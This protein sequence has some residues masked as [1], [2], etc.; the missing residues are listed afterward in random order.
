M[1]GSG[2][3]R[4]Y[5][6]FFTSRGH[7]AIARANL[8][9]REDATTLFTGSGMQPLVPYLLG[10]SHPA[11][12]RLVDSQPSLRAE[13]ID[14]I[15][16]TRHTTLFEMLGNW[17]LGS[18]FKQEQL[19]WIFEFLT[20]VVGL[21][22]SRIFASVF[23]G[24]PRWDIPRDTESELIWKDLFAD[25]GVDPV[26]AEP[27]TSARAALT[28]TGNAP[29]VAYDESECWWSRSGG[30]DTMPPGEPGG[31]DSEVFYFYP[32]VPHDERFGARC[33]P[34][35][36]CGR[37]VEIGN[38]VFMQYRRTEDGIE[39]LSQRNVDFGGGL[40]RLA[41][42]AI[43]TADVFGIDLLAPLVTAIESM[44]ASEHGSDVRAKRII[45]DHVRAVSFLAVD[46][47][48]PSNNTQGYV[49]RRL[50]RR[51][52]RQGL[53]LGIDAGLLPVLGDAVAAIYRDAYPE[54]GAR[55]A[56]ISSV[57]DREESLFRKTLARGMRELP[58]LAGSVLTGEAI[59]RLFDTY[60]FP[61]GLSVEEARATGLPVDPQWQAQYAVLMA[62]QKERS[63]TAA[64]GMFKA[65]S[66]TAPRPRRSCTR[67]PTCCTRRCGS[68]LATTL[69]SAAA[70][71]RQKG[72]G[73]TS[74]TRHE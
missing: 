6:D 8:V 35:C 2:I 34:Y 71:S 17:S 73:S 48:E 30:P 13:D 31:P 12:S 15:G 47:V 72:C 43:D 46:G 64:S 60:G 29:I 61:P 57:L 26:V 42:A 25:V 11:G 10:A 41:R 28:G 5:L 9:P 33:H 21:D 65:V 18:Y 63:R 22:P 27:G 62:Q 32:Q 45:A 16:D 49:M 58:R 66:P 69:C 74:P 23:V 56:Q 36:D 40:E 68:S 67:R 51:A 3:R 70:T 24:S 59:F 44:C 54:F 20:K 7:A 37:F 4:A 1:D 14:E 55:A 53:H 50:A 19:P 38:S 52:I 39:P